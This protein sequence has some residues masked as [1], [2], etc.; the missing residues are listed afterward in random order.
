[1]PQ[2]IDRSLNRKSLKFLI[3]LLAIISPLMHVA[4]DV[5]KLLN[6]NLLSVPQLLLTYASF[7]LLPLAVVGIFSL[8]WDRLGWFGLVGTVLYSVA[9]IYFA[10]T[11]MTPFTHMR[12]EIVAGNVSFSHLSDI[13]G[14]PYVIHGILMTIGGILFGGAILLSKTLPKLTGA[15]LIFGVIINVIFTIYPVGPFFIIGAII[16]NGAFILMGLYL[17]TLKERSYS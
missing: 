13:F 7:M 14:Q 17:I 12:S 3:G 15:L 6:N 8:Y 11:A 9:F 1:M 16:R 2:V 5:M 10:T 4:G